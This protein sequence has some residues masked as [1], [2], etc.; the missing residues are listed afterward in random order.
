LDESLKEAQEELNALIS[1]A[2]TIGDDFWV[3]IDDLNALAATYPGILDGYT[4]MKDGMIKLNEESVKKTLEN[5]KAE[6]AAN[7]EV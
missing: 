3:S 7:I 2:S 1:T 5:S 4:K 6:I